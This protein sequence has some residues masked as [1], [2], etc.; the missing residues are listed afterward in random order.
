MQVTFDKD[1]LLRA[2]KDVLRFVPTSPLHVYQR[3]VYM[4]ADKDSDRV[5]LFATSAQGGILRVLSDTGFGERP[6]MIDTSGSCALDARTLWEIVRKLPTNS[7]RLDTTNTTT[8][9]RAGRV[10]YVL[11]GMS[12]EVFHPMRAP[13]DA[14]RLMLSAKTLLHMLSCT[15]YAAAKTESR[16][17]LTGVH[18]EAWPGHLMIEATDSFRLAR[19][20]KR[21]TS[22][23]QQKVTSV[24]PADALAHL[25]ALLPDDDDE[26]VSLLF[27][28]TSVALTW[29]DGDIQV[30]LPC[31]EGAYPDTQKMVPTAQSDAF[32]L[33]KVDVMQAC[34]RVLTICRRTE[35]A[36]ARFHFRGSQLTLTAFAPEIGRVVDCVEGLSGSEGEMTLFFNVHYFLD[37]L[38]SMTV[39]CLSMKL[40]GAHVAAI[41]TYNQEEA[42]ALLMPM[43]Q[44]PLDAR[45][46]SDQS[47]SA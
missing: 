22:G 44:I 21:L 12:P 8:V 30:H 11:Q 42:I 16:P 23:S 5:E 1:A 6:V 2:L 45:V 9:L 3:F 25:I 40:C 47:A 24:I 18:I 38:R 14:T 4:R 41:L 28:P 15:V 31:L 29:C 46:I 39:D 19:I 34:E 32:V 7:V 20:T 36:V 35:N 26:P 17:I 33:P 27:G 43:R 10:K 37:A 13:Q